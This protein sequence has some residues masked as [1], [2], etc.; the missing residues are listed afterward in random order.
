MNVS[1][2]VIEVDRSAPQ[3]NEVVVDASNHIVGRLASI[4]AKWALEGRR[5]I[6]V[7]AEKAVVTGD[8]NMVLGWYKTRISEWLTHYNPEKAGPK[9]PRKPDRILKRVIRGMLPRK[10]SRGRGAF[11]R[12]RVFMGVPPQYVNADKVIIRG[13]LLAARPGVKYV[14]LEKLWKH[15][16]PKSYEEWIRG[17]MAWEARLKKAESKGGGK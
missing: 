12:V 9:I 4:V 11:K 8:F 17:K 13:A 7:N 16:E 6:I 1:N 5:V 14:T 10:S 15:I 2:R 3:L